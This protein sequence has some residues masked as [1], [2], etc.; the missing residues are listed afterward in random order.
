MAAPKAAVADGVENAPNLNSLRNVL[1][2]LF[3]RARG[4]AL[5]A[6]FEPGSVDLPTSARMGATP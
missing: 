5:D 2:E 4:D 3:E 1:A 6:E